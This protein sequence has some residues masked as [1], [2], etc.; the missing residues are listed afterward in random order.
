MTGT[1]IM[2]ADYGEKISSVVGGVAA[3]TYLSMLM[4]LLAVICIQRKNRIE[5]G[6][7]NVKLEETNQALQK[8]VEESQQ[9]TIAEQRADDLA[10]HDSLTGLPN[11]RRLAKLLQAEANC[12]IML[13]DLDRFKPINDL[14]GHEVGDAVLIEVASRL[15]KFSDKNN[16]E[17]MRIGGDEF[18]L[19]L[20]E[21]RRTSQIDRMAHQLIEIVSAPYTIG[22]RRLVLGCS[23][24]IAQRPKDCAD[25][26][27]IIRRADHAMYEAKRSGKN[28]FRHYDDE[29]GNRVQIKA[30]LEADLREA[31]SLDQ[32]D[33]HYQ[34]VVRLSD[35][36]IEGYEALARWSHKDQ[37]DIPPHI[38]IPIAEEANLI[39]DLTNIV[40][41]KACNA[42]SGWQGDVWVSVNISHVLVRDSWIIAKTFGILQQAGL[43]PHRLMVEITEASIVEDFSTAQSIIA[44]F[45]DAGIKVALD[46]FGTGYSSI[47][48]LR[49]LCFEHVKIDGSLI[50]EMGDSKTSR[51]AFALQGLA[52][53]MGV[54]LLAEGVE[55]LEASNQLLEI[56]F[57]RAQGHYYGKPSR[58]EDVDF[59]DDLKVA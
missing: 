10:R 21:P 48:V 54:R 28:R 27:D 25:D 51:I 3:S 15:R 2:L 1:M 12:T 26:K 38:F 33:V 53:A 6:L 52:K 43:P 30:T 19:L 5:L 56:G 14:H 8:A 49:D 35:G 18:L 40:L 57:E 22:E 34:P 20:S 16:A 32:I 36:K 4:M 46:D 29:I 50:R 31:I 13:I 58:N 11:R 41:R 23:I 39:E 9:K 44:A 55:S 17:V 45:T 37:G 59:Q 47:T 42:A 24:G 7:V